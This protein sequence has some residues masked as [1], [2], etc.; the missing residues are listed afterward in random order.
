[1]ARCKNWESGT[2]FP[3][4]DSAHTAEQLAACSKARSNIQDVFISA[5]PL[6]Q[7][8]H[9]PHSQTGEISTGQWEFSE[10]VAGPLSLKGC[11]QGTKSS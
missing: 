2:Y 7:S 5:R 1:M 3:L 8:P 11:D 6:I 9:T 4:A 10:R